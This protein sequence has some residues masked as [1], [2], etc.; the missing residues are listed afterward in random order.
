[1]TAAL[2][3]VGVTRASLGVQSFDPVVQRAINRVQ[4]VPMTATA[5]DG[6]RA[7]ASEASTST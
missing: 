4:T 7:L 1:M 2:G 3:R 5:V 6:L